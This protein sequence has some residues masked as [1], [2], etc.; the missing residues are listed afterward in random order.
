MF[1]PINVGQLQPCLG[2]QMLA[3]YFLSK[4][5]KYWKVANG[6][7]ATCPYMYT[8][9]CALCSPYKVISM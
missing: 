8:K 5:H 3:I 4:T 6:F 7:N 1:R 2:P 9:P